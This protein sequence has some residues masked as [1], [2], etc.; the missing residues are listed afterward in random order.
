MEDLSEG[1]RE[2][3]WVFP[4]APVKKEKR[5]ILRNRGEHYEV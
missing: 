4:L 3:P 1:E 2:S 5:R